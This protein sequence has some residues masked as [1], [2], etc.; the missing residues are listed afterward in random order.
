M[1]KGGKQRN[2]VI[3]LCAMSHETSAPKHLPP[4][5]KSS[6]AKGIKWESLKLLPSVLKVLKE[7]LN[8]ETLTPVQSAT[9][10][11]FLEHKDVAVEVRHS[12]PLI[13]LL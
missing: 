12:I 7:N 9:I 13:L 10:P 11:N 5:T 2:L 1:E 4:G 3:S 8:F 6:A